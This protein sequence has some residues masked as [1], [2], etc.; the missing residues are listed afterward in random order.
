MTYSHPLFTVL[1]LDSFLYDTHS[2]Y[3]CFT[4]HGIMQ[5]PVKAKPLPPL[6]P[7]ERGYE[8]LGRLTDAAGEHLGGALRFALQAEALDQSWATLIRAALDDMADALARGRWIHGLKTAH[9]A[10]AQYATERE[11]ERRAKARDVKDKDKDKD[12]ESIAESVVIVADDKERV[13]R[14]RTELTRLASASNLPMPIGTPMHLM[15]TLAPLAPVPPSHDLDFDLVPNNRACT[16]TAGVFS[17]PP[18]NPR[19]PETA[20]QI[21]YGLNEWHVQAFDQLAKDGH[22]VRLVG[23]TFAF[24]GV[25]SPDI[26]TSLVKVLRIAIYVRLSLLLEQRLLASL[27]V[28]LSF[29]K[30]PTPLPSPQPSSRAPSPPPPSLVPQKRLSRVTG[31]LRSAASSGI[32]SFISRKTESLLHRPSSRSGYSSDGYS[33]QRQSLDIPPPQRGH[34]Q[35]WSEDDRGEGLETVRAA[36]PQHAFGK[37]GVAL[38]HLQEIAPVLSTSPD[39][40]VPLPS[41]LLTLADREKATTGKNGRRKTRLLLTGDERT[42]LEDLRGW[43]EHDPFVFEHAFAGFQQMT[44]L[45]SEHCPQ[46]PRVFEPGTDSVLASISRCGPARWVTYQYYAPDQDEC[47]GGEIER[48]CEFAQE[49]CEL[50]DI[51]R[52]LHSLTW[53]HAGVKVTA[54]V[55]A[56]LSKEMSP[57]LKVWESCSVCSARNP[58]MPVDDAI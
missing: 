53:V 9:K 5:S 1:G 35:R 42:A 39:M 15:L 12:R 20:G 7:V 36:P 6:P 17:L 28:P 26:Y 30:L 43:D 55:D 22:S 11:R 18:T 37:F 32:W 8:T 40:D 2:R 24:A 47:I 58:A 31:G 16:F 27:H 44:M 3:S 56:A 13:S 38:K 41:L 45:Y 29:P 34:A 46:P 57:E 48:L 19:N 10:R 21:L 23:G 50:C 33:S 52:R 25:S 4:P 54:N 14:A 51:P 49:P